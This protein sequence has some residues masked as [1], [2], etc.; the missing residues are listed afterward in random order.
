M[1]NELYFCISLIAALFIFMLDYGL[2]KPGD[3]RPNYYSLLFKWS[4]YL[5]KRRLKKEGAW[6]NLWS[7]YVNQVYASKTQLQKFNVMIS[8]REIVFTTARPLFTWENVLGMC[9]IC[10]HFW[11]S[12]FLFTLVNI[13]C[14]KENIIIFGLYFLFS[15]LLIR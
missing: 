13:I 10:T 9:P 6:D 7:Q 1:F 2:G 11:F 14:Q 15:H 5:A 3:E 8:F 12:F 4:F